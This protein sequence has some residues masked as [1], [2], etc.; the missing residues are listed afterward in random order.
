MVEPIGVV[1]ESV[2]VE[3]PA[4]VVYGLIADLPRMGEWSPECRG[5]SWLRG[6]DRAEVGARF[7]GRNRRGVRRWSTRGVVVVADPGQ[8]VAWDIYAL[9]LP[10]GRWGYGI[11]PLPGGGCRVTESWQDRRGRLLTLVGPMGTGVKDRQAH[12]R[13][14]MRR[15]LSNLKAAAEAVVGGERG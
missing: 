8:Q 12:N 9:G 14:G 6:W 1:E 13:E 10:G 15:T 2:D 7:I 3:A 5:V 4:E 11:E